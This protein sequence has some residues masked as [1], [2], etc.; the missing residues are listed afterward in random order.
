MLKVNLTAINTLPQPN[1]VLQSLTKNVTH[2]T[3]DPKIKEIK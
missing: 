3:P 2:K 1:L